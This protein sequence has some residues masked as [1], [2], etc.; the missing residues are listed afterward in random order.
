VRHNRR[1]FCTL[2]PERKN[3]RKTLVSVIAIAASILPASAKD[4]LTFQ[5]GVLSI[6]PARRRRRSGFYRGRLE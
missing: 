2:H 4:L 6:Q 3:M 5:V 1:H